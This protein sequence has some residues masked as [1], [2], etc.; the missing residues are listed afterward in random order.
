MPSPDNLTPIGPLSHGQSILNHWRLRN[1]ERCPECGFVES[2]GPNIL[3]AGEGSTWAS[4]V[5]GYG[6]CRQYR[7][8]TAQAAV[9]AMRP[10]PYEAPKEDLFILWNPTSDLPPRKTFATQAEAEEVAQKMAARHQTLFYV[11]KLV[12]VANVEYLTIPNVT[13]RSTTPP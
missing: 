11:A 3:R 10:E 12:S 1:N 7:E 9:K 5:P 8:R 13:L 6:D 4:M 2:N